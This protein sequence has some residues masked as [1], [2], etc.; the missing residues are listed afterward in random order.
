MKLTY[1]KNKNFKESFQLS[2]N[3][4]EKNYQFNLEE[5]VDTH[6]EGSLFYVKEGSKIERINKANQQKLLEKTLKSEQIDDFIEKVEGIYFGVE[7]NAKRQEIRVFTDKLDR[8]EVFYCELDDKILVSTNLSDIIDQSGEYGENALISTLLLTYPP[9]GETFYK[10]INRTRHNEIL[11][12]KGGKLE[13]EVIETKPIAIKEYSDDHIEEYQ[14]I[15]VNSILSRTSEDLNL[16]Q[17]SAGWDSTFMLSVLR[18]HLPAE[19]LQTV[20]FHMVQS[21]GESFNASEIERV[22]KISEYFG[23]KSNIVDVNLGSLE[24]VNFW[25]NYVEN[26]VKNE[27]LCTHVFTHFKLSEFVENNFKIKGIDYAI[28][29]GECCDSV[30][31]FGYSQGMTMLHDSRAFREYADKMSIYLYSPTFYKKL[32]Q[33]THGDDRVYQILKHG[34]F[35]GK[36]IEDRLF[37]WLFDFTFRKPI[38]NVFIK[39]DKLESFKDWVRENYFEKI[40]QN[41]NEETLYYWLNRIYLD[42]H[43]QGANIN[44]I[45]AV[46]PDIRMPYYDYNLFKFLAAAPENWGRNLEMNPTKYPMKRLI[47]SKTYDF[48]FHLFSKGVSS[49]TSEFN[50][51]VSWH[52]EIMRKSKLADHYFQT[53]NFDEKI[54]KLFNTNSFNTDKMKNYVESARDHLIDGIDFN[55]LLTLTHIK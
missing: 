53:V 48:P 37:A 46:T 11:V 27:G 6:L 42:F 34:K 13:V 44:K 20:T 50:P 4:N 29:N 16:V 24:I 8:K 23:V 36:N 55:L 43:F 22:K 10:N 15:L 51:G 28:F 47:H 30:H 49:Y 31:N 39:Q 7:I 45:M 52:D 40:I 33:G 19:K 25:K 3:S 32:V 35:E 5:G 54:E 18:K 1:L 38:D 2:E 14:D 41:I 26:K 9:K 21:N 12:I 17:L